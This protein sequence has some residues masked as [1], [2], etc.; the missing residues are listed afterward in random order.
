MPARHDAL[1]YHPAARYHRP[2]SRRARPFM[3]EHDRIPDEG[4]VHQAVD[5]LKIRATE[6]DV[7]RQDQQLAVGRRWSRTRLQRD[8]PRRPDDERGAARRRQ[9]AAP[10][11]AARS[12]EPAPTRISD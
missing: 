12:A 4:R 6:P 10:L 9:G 5:D 1:A 8:V 11:T 3:A 2:L 7:L